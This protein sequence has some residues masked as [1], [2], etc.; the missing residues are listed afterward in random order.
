MCFLDIAYKNKNISTRIDIAYN[1]GN[2]DFHSL[3]SRGIMPRRRNQNQA[4]KIY[5][6]FVGIVI[7]VLFIIY[8]G[9][10]KDP[11]TSIERKTERIDINL[12]DRV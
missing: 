2:N 1:Y 9:F 11:T 8:L 12:E 5:L 4:G 7:F 6:T 3:S 10:V